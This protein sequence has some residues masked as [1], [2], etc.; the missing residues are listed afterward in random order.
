MKQNSFTLFLN[1]MVLF[2]VVLTLFLSAAPNNTLAST[3]VP[4][5]QGL[6]ANQV[7]RIKDIIDEYY[8][9]ELE[10]IYKMERKALELYQELQREDAFADEAKAAEAS[11]KF[12]GLVKDLSNLMAD[13]LRTRTEYF[14]KVKHVLTP[15]QKTQLI[16]S[17]NV[18]LEPQDGITIYY[19]VDMEEILGAFTPEQSKKIVKLQHDLEVKMANI[20]RELELIEIDFRQ[21]L[22]KDQPD[23]KKVKKI[24]EKSTELNIELMNTVVDATLKFKDVLTIEQKKRLRH[25]IL[26]AARP[27]LD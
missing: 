4:F 27:E 6:T 17:L 21:E 19:E 7:N 23:S 8:N 26:T 16:N 20:K 24:V 3:A 14:L 2:S 10:I 15:E 9:R 18:D 1:K 25:F 5:Q 11:K 13:L 22:A 12:K